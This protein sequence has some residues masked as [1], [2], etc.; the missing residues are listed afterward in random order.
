MR[1]ST[2][3]RLVTPLFILGLMVMPLLSQAQT[4]DVTSERLGAV[5]D[6]APGAPT[7]NVSIIASS[8]T[9]QSGQTPPGSPVRITD[10]V[11]QA[12][13]TDVQAA[14]ETFHVLG[15]AVAVF[16]GDEI[17]YNRGFGVRDLQSSA[18]I[19]PRTR[20]RI[21]SNTKS[22]SSLML[23]T[24]IDEGVLDWDTRAVDLWPGFRA[25][26]DELTQSLRVRDLLG[27]G[28]GLAESPTF[29][30]YASSGSESALDLLRSVAY[31]PVIAL[32][33]TQYYYNNTLFAAAAYLGLL[34]QKTPP[35]MLE[36]TY[37][38]LIRQRV[39][40]PIGMADAA[41]ASDPRPLG[42]DYATGYTR[43]LFGYPSAV[44]FASIAGA[45]PAGAGLASTTDMARYLIT[46]MNGGVTPE[47]TRI[48]SA[49]NLAETH[50][51]G[52]LLE[53]GAF[54]P[55]EL[56]PDTASLNY[57]MGW[58][59]ETFKDNRRLI[60]HAGG[61]DGFA[62]L[63]GFFP[64]DRLGFVILTN[65]E[66]GRGGGIFNLYLQASLMSLL[67]GLNR[68]VPSLLADAAGTLEEQ[69]AALAAQTQ[70][71]DPATVTPYLG[72]YSNGFRLR[73]E[74]PNSLRL[75]HDIRSLPLLALSDGGYVV[76]D[77]PSV[78]MGKKVTFSSGDNGVPM[79]TIEGFE[80]LMWLTG[81]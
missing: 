67:F 19:T 44:P 31:L 45:A 55:T 2:I 71:V 1:K 24:F 5:R 60:W 72:L 35:E 20:F 69:M 79:M 59:N 74:A 38:A 80:P 27:M 49:A 81:G 29:E 47:G 14:M 76:A 4:G 7:A 32:P 50:V 48:V 17:I 54:L 73:L 16:Q 39:F 78:V 42:D 13:E 23:A 43:D 10:A 57:G 36:S 12:F 65:L 77:G 75:E 9:A 18:P 8:L 6:L 66:P 22:M 26:T 33:H 25:P 51:P 46:Q 53:P 61:I 58:Y 64:E 11:L 40:E 62:S 63:M 21:G 37:A 52:I 3:L 30:F 70:P 56:Q 41:I 34:V 28:S 15:A 68:E